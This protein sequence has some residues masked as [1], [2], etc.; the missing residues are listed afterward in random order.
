[1]SRRRLIAAGGGPSGGGGGP[2]PPD[3]SLNTDRHVTNLAGLNELTLTPTSLITYRAEHR[4]AA[5]F[6]GLVLAY[7]SFT[8]A[9]L[10]AP[11]SATVALEDPDGVL[12]PVTWDGEPTLSA[13]PDTMVESDPIDI[14]IGEGSIYWTRILLPAGVDVPGFGTGRP[15]SRMAGNHLSGTW[16]PDALPEGTT[17]SMLFC[18]IPQAHIG[19]ARASTVVPA[20][21]GDSIA[22]QGAYA[23]GWF[24]LACDATLVP[25]LSYGRG[26]RK[27]T[28]LDGREGD[29]LRA[30][31]HILSEYG[32][33]DVK[34]YGYEEMWPNALA[35]YAYVAALNPAPVWQ[36]TCTPVGVSSSDG[37]VSYG[38]QTVVADEVRAQWNAFLRDGAPCHPTTKA[39]L[40]VGATG[41]VIRAGDDGHPLAGIVE[42][43]A[44][45]EQGGSSAPTGK[46]NFSGS[47]PYT[48]DGTHP[49]LS[50]Q[51]PMSAPVIDW[52]ESLTV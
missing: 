16:T 34:T 51:E 49:T 10:A 22:A 30:A 13:D 37:Y 23:G 33:N 20:M 31:T 19:K 15:M 39:A 46:W 29:T 18:P 40:A 28:S 45:V 27:F 47:T 52:I 41:T 4:C 35:F 12:H 14:Q 7:G 50:G 5:D 32:A 1:M 36:T 2:L 9:A 42:V 44:T 43:A 38:N 3:P 17:P 11:W 48:G 24:R 21:I 25:A 6:D 26:V 8:H